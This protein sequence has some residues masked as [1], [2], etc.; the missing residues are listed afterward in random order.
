M[1]HKLWKL[2]HRG[3]A[4]Q[5]SGAGFRE[6]LNNMSDEFILTGP[7]ASCARI[8]KTVRHGWGVG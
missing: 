7:T 8:G 3:M 4:A 1:R 2:T 5:S 6:K